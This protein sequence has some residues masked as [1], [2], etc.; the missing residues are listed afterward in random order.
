MHKCNYMYMYNYYLALHSGGGK[1]RNAGSGDDLW[2]WSWEVE[3]GWESKMLHGA[4]ASE[5]D[6][7]NAREGRKGGG[8]E[9]RSRG[10]RLAAAVTSSFMN[11]LYFCSVQNKTYVPVEKNENKKKNKEWLFVSSS[12]FVPPYSAAPGSSRNRAGPSDKLPLWF[13]LKMDRRE[14][15]IS[16]KRGRR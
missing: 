2:C 1:R 15:S 7:V 5:R 13:L 8:G 10:G 6:S 4:M 3:G 12:S 14:Y 9:E 11:S 16:K